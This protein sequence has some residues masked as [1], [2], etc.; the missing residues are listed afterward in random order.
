MG[1]AGHCAGSLCIGGHHF[2]LESVAV[3]YSYTV[4][5][6]S[7]PGLPRKRG[8]AWYTLF[9]HARIFKND[10]SQKTVGVYVNT[11]PFSLYSGPSGYKTA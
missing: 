10:A 9:T 7:F 1:L 4:R 3:Q 5:V 8:K 11:V 2:G 6:A